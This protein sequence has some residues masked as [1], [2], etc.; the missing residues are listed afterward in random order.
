[1]VSASRGKALSG[2]RVAYG[3]RCRSRARTSQRDE[4]RCRAAGPKPPRRGSHC[5]ESRPEARSRTG[6]HCQ[7]SRPR[8]RSQ[9]REPARREPRRCRLD[10]RSAVPVAG[11]AH[12]GYGSAPDRGRPAGGMWVLLSTQDVT[13]VYTIHEPRFFVK[14]ERTAGSGLP[15]SRPPGRR[16]PRPRACTRSTPSPRTARPPTST[17]R[18]DR[19]PRL[20]HRPRHDHL[21]AD[22]PHHVP[23]AD[24]QGRP[25]GPV[26][27]ARLRETIA[28]PGD[29]RFTVGGSWEPEDWYYAQTN[30]GTWTVSF[31]LDRAYGGIACSR[32]ARRPWPSTARP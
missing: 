20:G 6:S 18:A 19:R 21:G 11:A 30:A 17:S 4:S 23:L 10:R 9:T 24:R 3:G 1:M 25:R 26:Q 13:D 5:Q 31:P 27:S 32:A 7:E 22:E 14:T 28:D 2:W 12:D 8:A 29:L 15:A 16:A